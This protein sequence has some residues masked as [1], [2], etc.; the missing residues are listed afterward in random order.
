[1][2]S[3]K[4]YGNISEISNII[5]LMKLIITNIVRNITSSI[6]YILRNLIDLPYDFRNNMVRLRLFIN[7]QFLKFENITETN[8]DLGLE[9]LR[10][11]DIKDAILR[12][13]IAR[14]LFEKDSPEIHYYLGWCYFLN[15]NKDMALKTLE[16]A[17]SQDTVGLKTFIE[18][19]EKCDFVPHEIWFKLREYTMVDSRDKYYAKDF[20]NKVVELPLEFISH[21]LLTI[22]ELKPKSQILD[23]GAAT[24]I[25]G[26]YLD[27]QISADYEITAV[28]EHQVYLEYA[29]DLRG[30]RGFVYDKN[31]LES[32]HKIKNIF[33]KK[34]YDVVLSFDG[35]SFVRNLTSYFKIIHTGLS[36]EGIF[37]LLLPTGKKT[38][39]SPK[40]LSYIYDKSDIE[41]QLGLAKFDIVSIKEW[42]LY[43]KGKYVSFICKKH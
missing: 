21:F 4:L 16:K 34:K 9:H 36:K 37:T 14:W 18:N 29:K 38:E 33:T 42:S 1:L 17:K 20:Y 32:L 10:N 19:P 41:K 31:I 8:I 3:G 25:I 13:R 15:G 12:F 7:D 5:S 28:D 22:Q 39:W 35:L 23:L 6:S 24:G 11:G 30:E 27:Y 40:G 2:L 26:S 43:K